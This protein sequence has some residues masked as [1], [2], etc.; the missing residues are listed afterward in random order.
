MEPTPPLDK[1][2]VSRIYS[3][4]IQ[5]DWDCQPIGLVTACSSKFK[6][7]HHS[8]LNKIEQ[9]KIYTLHVADG[10]ENVVTVKVASQLTSLMH[11][12]TVGTV[13]KLLRFNPVPFIQS[14]SPSAQL[15]IALIV[16]NFEICGSMEVPEALIKHPRERLEVQ[17]I[18][19]AGAAAEVV[20][21]DEGSTIVSEAMSSGPHKYDDPYLNALWM[22]ASKWEP[23]ENPVCSPGNRLCSKYGV[24]FDTCVC[25]AIPIG[26]QE[27]LQC[28]R[29]CPFVTMEVKAMNNDKKRN[30]L[31]WW[32]MT[33]V[34]S[35]C[36]K[37]KRRELPSCLLWHIRA[38]FPNK[39]GNRYKGFQPGS[40]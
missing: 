18:P 7:I 8:S 37:E 29:D 26:R 13:L 4:E 30:L 3:R 11:R 1:D 32:Y 17:L 12:I 24:R 23:V 9:K 14:T 15:Q 36:G 28:A 25:D 10:D 31:D 21:A 2:F 38:Y 20:G 35:I 27:L 19:P 33:N 34:Y 40:R 6:E 5:S 16:T 39:R 22:D